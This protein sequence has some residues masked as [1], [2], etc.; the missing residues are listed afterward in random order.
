[1]KKF[2]AALFDLLVIGLILIVAAFLVSYN[3]YQWRELAILFLTIYLVNCL[4]IFYMLISDDELHEKFIWV[5][6][7]VVFPIISHV[8]FGLFRIRRY[9][10]ISRQQY[11]QQLFDLCAV[12]TVDPQKNGLNHFETEH[13]KVIKRPF[14]WSEIELYTHGFDAYQKLFDDLEQ[15]QKYIY[16]EM[17]IIKQSEIFEKFKE[18]LIRKAQTGVEIKIILD[19]FGTWVVQKKDFEYLRKNKIEIKIFNKT[20]YPIVKPTD[21][22]RLHRK[23]FIIDGQIV[24]A[25]GLNITDEYSSYSA[26]YGYWADLNF[27]LK[28]SI[29][30]D[31]EMIFLYDWMQLSGQK[32]SCSN[33]L[34][35]NLPTS[36]PTQ[37]S[38][39]ILL[40]D[41]GPNNYDNLLENTL[42]NWIYNAKKT[43]RLSTPYFI[44]TRQIFNALK[45]ALKK[46]V[47]IEIY[48]PGKPDKKI[49]YYGTNFYLKQLVTFG[50]QVFILNNIFLHSKFAI[51]DDQFVYIGTNNL[52]MRSLYTNYEVINIIQGQKT[53][54]F[55]NNLCNQY[56]VYA[57][58]LQPHHE[59]RI[60]TNFK[61]V[62]YELFAPLM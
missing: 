56:Q 59:S 19:C 60:K 57:K 3:R 7:L 35:S 39:R 2:K 46:G 13:I 49:V 55:L 20:I 45:N 6:F 31:Y 38:E 1:M 8:I 30:H 17:Y 26:Y 11:D 16:I 54:T 12:K 53:I 18:V 32:L 62:I 14:H 51:F 5:F 52:D 36:E 48:I 21:N 42:V 15:A 23:F 37:N 28:G 10:G 43:I 50:A 41:E 4:F 34:M 29:V 22:N 24:H 25:G 33:C 44:P 61:K 40:F 47:A 58:L 27:C 9:R